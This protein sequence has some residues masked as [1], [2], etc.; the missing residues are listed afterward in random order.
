MALNRVE[1]YN[2][3]EEHLVTLCMRVELR[4][5]INVLDFHLHSENF[6]RDLFNEL[7]TWK[8]ENLNSQLQN[9]EAIDLIDRTKKIIIQVSATKTKEKVENSLGKKL[10]K[11]AAY[12]GFNFKFISI[13]KDAGNLRKCSYNPPN[14]IKFAPATDI[15]DVKSILHD[16]YNLDIE[17]F[18]TIYRL[19]QSEL[20]KE[21][22][23]IRLESNLSSVINV[24]A[25]ENLGTTY[26]E[27]N[28]NS[29]EI[30]RK[31]DYN[32]LGSSKYIIEDYKLYHHI[33]DKIY[34]EFDKN[35]CN[36]SI[37]VL[38]TIRSE[39]V[40]HLPRL[41]DDSDALFNLIIEKISERVLH[42][43]NFENI[44]QEEMDMCIGIL[45]VDAFIR[46]K[47]FENPNN[48]NYVAAR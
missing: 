31:I 1:F 19:I 13:A 47:I 44:P 8:L 18:K 21:T 34:S 32:K 45:I 3:I 7:Y 24:L 42:S 27:S 4:G 5:K 37:S 6:Y 28:I 30:E 38:N 41:S 10:L 17:K 25:K 43:S 29:F 33:V 12:N 15:Y 9:I 35:G 26:T 36:K 40:K 2:Y 14:G 39:Y 22:D 20:G 46:C 48:Y 16:I 11:E 23:T